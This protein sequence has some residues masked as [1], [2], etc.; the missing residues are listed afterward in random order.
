MNDM[1]APCA[2]KSDQLNADDLIYGPITVRIRDTN[3]LNQTTQPVS[4]YYDGDNGKPYKPCKSM[5]KVMKRVWG[6]DSKKYIGQSLTLYNDPDVRYGA[7]KTGGIRISHMSGVDHEITVTLSESKT[8]RKP[9]V[10]KPLHVA[11]GPDRRPLEAAAISAAEIAG[12]GGQSFGDWMKTLSKEDQSYI[13]ADIGRYQGIASKARAAKAGDAS[14]NTTGE[15][16]F[17]M[18]R[19]PEH[20]RA[21]RS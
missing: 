8:A 14:E 11:L 15:A 17:E 5:C 9:F 2:V 18:G 20:E 4:L 1:D 3:V 21:G 7:N 6:S 16:T 12:N 10:V 13:K 19:A